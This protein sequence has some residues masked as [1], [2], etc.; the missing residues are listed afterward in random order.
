[1]VTLAQIIDAYNA[2]FPAGYGPLSDG[3]PVPIGDGGDSEKLPQ[4]PPRNSVSL[5][6]EVTR[7][8]RKVR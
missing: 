2:S 5:G 8:I 7:R 4:R 6:H 1:M 3:I